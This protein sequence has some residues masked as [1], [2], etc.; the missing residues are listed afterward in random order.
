MGFL[1]FSQSSGFK[2][3]QDQRDNFERGKKQLSSAKIFS[4]FGEFKEGFGGIL[5]GIEKDLLRGNQLAGQSVQANFSRAGLGSTGLG[6]GILKGMQQGTA[7]AGAGIRAKIFQDLM[8]KVIGIQ[9]S[10]AGAEFN[11]Q[12]VGRG[13][14]SEFS[15][16]GQL[17]AAAGSTALDAYIEKKTK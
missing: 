5:G 6:A 14:G 12:I 16:G 13:P 4:R 11:R 8:D 7:I 3:R 1:D 10:L 17:A 9:T 2:E 15:A